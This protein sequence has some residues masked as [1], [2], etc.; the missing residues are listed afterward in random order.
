M[1]K[2]LGTVGTMICAAGLLLGVYA[3][4]LGTGHDLN[5]ADDWKETASLWGAVALVGVGC[6]LSV[7][8]RKT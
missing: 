3:W 4:S 2:H 8:G 7:F 1:N 5:P 6:V